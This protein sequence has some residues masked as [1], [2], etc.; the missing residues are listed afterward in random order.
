MG[1]AGLL[2]KMK[3]IVQTIFSRNLNDIFLKYSIM[4]VDYLIFVYQ[5][6]WPSGEAEV[7]KTSY[8]GSNPPPGSSSLL[9][10]RE[11]VR[12]CPKLR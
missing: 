5:P 7:C 1:E 6:G 12:S 11:G 3:Q 2:R 9:S 8:G 10:I 4:L